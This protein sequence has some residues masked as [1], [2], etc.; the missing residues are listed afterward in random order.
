MFE[1]AGLVADDLGWDAAFRHPGPEHGDE[2][3]GRRFFGAGIGEENHVDGL[4]AFG[5][6]DDHGGGVNAG[7]PGRDDGRAI[8]HWSY[9]GR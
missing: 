1:V 8:N 2:R 6:L 7:P 5:E 4:A 9:P 3:I